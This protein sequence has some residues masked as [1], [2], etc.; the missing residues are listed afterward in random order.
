M[1]LLLAF[2][3]EI[4]F[5]NARV[6]FFM[7]TQ[8]SGVGIQPYPQIPTEITSGTKRIQTKYY[9]SPICYWG[10]IWNICNLLL[11]CIIPGAFPF[12]SCSTSL[13][14]FYTVLYWML[15]KLI[16]TVKVLSPMVS[17]IFLQGCLHCKILFSDLKWKI[18]TWTGFKTRICRSLPFELSLFSLR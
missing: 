18:R 9:S 12:I 11:C 3:M 17:D 4:P 16:L 15:V 10:I 14:L 2:T 8:R 7:W 5:L 1:Q 13:F 6:F